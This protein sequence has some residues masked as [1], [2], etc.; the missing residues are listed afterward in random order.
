MMRISYLAT[1][2][3][4]YQAP[5]SDNAQQVV[6]GDFDKRDAFAA[7]GQWNFGVQMKTWF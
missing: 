2:E 3:S 6:D 7:G 5:Q 4:L 1:A